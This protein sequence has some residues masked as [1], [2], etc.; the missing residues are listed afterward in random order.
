MILIDN[1]ICDKCGTCISVC[2]ENALEL[3]DLLVLNHEACCE[4]QNCVAVCPFGALRLS[5]KE[6]M[7]TTV[8]DAGTDI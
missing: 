8:G 3:I 6:N 5:D 1:N 2:P 7:E 4:C